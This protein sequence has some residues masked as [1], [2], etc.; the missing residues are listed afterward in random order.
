MGVISISKIF[1]FIEDQTEEDI[2]E[3][4]ILSDKI[5]TNDINF[6]KFLSYF[7]EHNDILIEYMCH[8]DFEKA[9][10]LLTKF[11]NVFQI[12][13]IDI[14]EKVNYIRE[15][16]TFQLVRVGDWEFST[17]PLISDTE[18]K[19]LTCCQAEFKSANKWGKETS[20][21]KEYI[22][23]D[24][25]R[26]VI[27]IKNIYKKP[28]YFIKFNNKYFA[29]ES[30]FHKMLYIYKNFNLI[31]RK[32][33]VNQNYDNLDAIY[34][35]DYYEGNDCERIEID[36]SD[37]FPIGFFYRGPKHTREWNQ[38]YPKGFNFYKEVSIQNK[39]LR[40]EIE[41]LSYPHKGYAL[42]DL[43][44]AKVIEAKKYEIE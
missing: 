20:P 23:H 37:Y 13:N 14:D 1:E 15:Y 2:K 34:K 18:E 25:N 29:I 24:E 30:N 42:L 33:T 8:V 7:R 19:C 5:N 44:N 17:I 35:E 26:N 27:W 31:T 41:N 43:E 38:L 12:Q 3:K 40:I 11:I 10:R 28:I 32:I 22:I 39:L 21:S 6:E 36:L 16:G 9:K 4:Y